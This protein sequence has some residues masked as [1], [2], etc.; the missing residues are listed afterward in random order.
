MSSVIGPP[1]LG[2]TSRRS[3]STSNVPV[4]GTYPYIYQFSYPITSNIRRLV[5]MANRVS[6]RIV[7][8]SCGSPIG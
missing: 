8:Q 5:T 6:I 4:T 1:Y 2:R 3:T 7:P